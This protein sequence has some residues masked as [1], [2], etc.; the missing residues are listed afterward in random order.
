MNDIHSLRTVAAIVL[1]GGLVATLAGCDPSG[2]T[3]TETVASTPTETPTETPTPTPTPTVEPFVLDCSSIIPQSRRDYV[4]SLGG[5]LFPPADFF[6]KNSSAPSSPYLLM[7]NNGG[8]ICAYGGGLELTYAY[9]YA[10]L[11]DDAQVA[12]VTALIL[13]PG[14]T[15]EISS[16]GG[17]TLYNSNTDGN[18]FEFF[19]VVPGAVYNASSVELIDEMIA[20]IP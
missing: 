19:L 6:A 15:Y 13:G 8:I 20:T 18:P 3:P 11:F 2:P 10:P 9:G 12:E 7:Q 17:G 1:A 14:D 5:T 4:A 16:Y